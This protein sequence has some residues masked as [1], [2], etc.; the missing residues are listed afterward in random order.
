[1]GGV[2]CAASF[3]FGWVL[4]RGFVRLGGGRAGSRFHGHV[5]RAASFAFDCVLS[6]GFVHLGGG[7]VTSLCFAKEK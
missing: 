2:V 3:G 6:Q 7:R 4:S 1:V 5:A